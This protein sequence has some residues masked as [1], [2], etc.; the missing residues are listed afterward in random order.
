MR[1]VVAWIEVVVEALIIPLIVAGIVGLALG[2]AW[3][4]EHGGRWTLIGGI[5]LAIFGLTV[6]AAIKRV[7]EK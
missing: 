4:G 7:N 5:S 3:L 1:Y 2:A 6:W